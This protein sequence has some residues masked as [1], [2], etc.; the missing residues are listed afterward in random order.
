MVGSSS[1]SRFHFLDGEITGKSAA[2]KRTAAFLGE[3]PTL[4]RWKRLILPGS[5]QPRDEAG[6]QPDLFPRLGVG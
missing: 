4:K 1:V 6:S 3:L 5:K 2:G